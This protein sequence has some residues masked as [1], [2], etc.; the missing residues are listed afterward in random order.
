MEQMFQWNRFAFFLELKQF[1]YHFAR[2][3][4]S[5]GRML[6]EL[7]RLSVFAL[8]SLGHLLFAGPSLYKWHSPIHKEMVSR[9]APV[10]F[11]RTY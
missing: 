8:R 10:H 4:T 5:F 1:T 7:A 9:N 11:P 2:T 3:S 6:W